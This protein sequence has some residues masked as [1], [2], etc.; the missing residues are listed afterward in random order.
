MGGTSGTIALRGKFANESYRLFPG[1][2][3][4]LSVQLGPDRPAL[5]LPRDLVLSDQQGEY[6]FVV[7]ADSRAKRHNIRTS[8]L[9]ANLK[10]VLSGLSAGDQ[11]VSVG[12]NKLSDGQAVK[13]LAGSAPQAA[14]VATTAQKSGGH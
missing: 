2:Y 8:N 1:L 9:P 5:T 10:E 7:D 3:A 6:V 11:V 13:A 14:A 4:Q 12:Y